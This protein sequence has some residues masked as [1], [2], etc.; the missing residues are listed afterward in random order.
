LIRNTK[1]AKKLIVHTDGGHVRD[2]EINSRSFEA[3]VSVVYR[4]ENLVQKDKNHQSILDKTCVASCKD[5]GLKTSKRFL[6]YAALK[7]GLT[8]ETK[9]T[10]FADG[11]KNCWSIINVLKPHCS[12]LE[13]VLDWFHIGE[14]FQNTIGVLPEEYEETLLHIKWCVWH[15]DANEALSRLKAL[16]N[17]IDDEKIRDK[18]SRLLT[19]IESNRKYLVN[20]ENRRANNKSI[21]SQVAESVIGSLINKR[22]KKNQKMRWTREAAHNLLQ[23]RTSR[24]SGDL[25]KTW[26]IAMNEFLSRKIKSSAQ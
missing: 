18:I 26:P 8:K 19:Y 22:Y 23:I 16:H 6:H 21:S 14:K 17:T 4:P 3:V 10:A 12:E 2:R 24:M 9:I 25:E 5:D 11:A 15:N 7:Q 1:P 13:C 20:Y